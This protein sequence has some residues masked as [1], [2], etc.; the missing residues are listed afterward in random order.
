MKELTIG[1]KVVHE[2]EKYE[3]LWVDQETG[4]VIVGK[5]TAKA[6]A[7]GGVQVDPVCSI[8]EP[9]ELEEAEHEL[10]A[11]EYVEKLKAVFGRA[12][13]VSEYDKDQDCC[14][15][16]KCD[17]CP[18]GDEKLRGIDFYGNC[19]AL[20]WYHPEK[21]VKLIDEWL[22]EREKKTGKT[23]L[24]D[25]REK[26]PNSAVNAGGR[27]GFCRRRLYGSGDLSG[28]EPGIGCDVCWNT[29]MP[30]VEDNAEG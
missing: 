28:C 11:A 14:Y 17:D 24:E 6:S 1:K 8:A 27:P 18:F 7:G 30:E 19:S 10:T 21:A 2:G 16:M 22:A 4:N 12:A 5:L 23:Y 15:G 26:F 29:V 9:G 25:F 3:I 20:V 13:V